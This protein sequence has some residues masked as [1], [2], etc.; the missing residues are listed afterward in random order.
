MMGDKD[1]AGVV[2]ALAASPTLVGGTV[3]C[4]QL[5]EER[6]LPAADLAAAWSAVGAPVTVAAEPDPRRALDR[7]LRE[8]RGPVVVAGSLYLVGVVRAAL[9]DD[10]D[11]RDPDDPPVRR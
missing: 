9:V 3:V 10:P 11:L 1:V 5:P 2:A 6:A 7:V 8:A 4:T